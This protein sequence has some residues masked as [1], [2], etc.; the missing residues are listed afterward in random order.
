MKYNILTLILSIQLYDPQ[1]RIILCVS[2]DVKEYI[3]EFPL[4][5]SCELEYYDVEIINGKVSTF[6]YNMYHCL[7]YAVKKYGECLLINES[8]LMVNKI[9]ISDEIK[10]QGYAFLKR[11]FV[12]HDAKTNMHTYSFNLLYLNNVTFLENLKELI[13]EDINYDIETKILYE[14][15]E[16]EE[17][18]QQATPSSLAL[19]LSTSFIIP[20]LSLSLS[21]SIIQ[22]PSSALPSPS[23]TPPP[24]PMW[25]TPGRPTSL[26][27][28]F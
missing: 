4:N 9:Q 27:A 19:A 22:A 14:D 13:L 12:G 10:Q 6:Y 17:E 25:G 1:A 5:I 18:R 28:S 24:R 3:C 21:P 8:A 20:P 7:T 11:Y 16:E 15:P 26:L 2:E 23:P